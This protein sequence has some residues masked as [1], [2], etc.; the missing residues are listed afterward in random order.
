MDRISDLEKKHVLKVLESG[1]KTSSLGRYNHLLSEK[2]KKLTKSKYA[3]TVSSGTA[4]LH[5]SLKAL[6]IKI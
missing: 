2:F 5:V 3:I 4:A 6:D 1:F